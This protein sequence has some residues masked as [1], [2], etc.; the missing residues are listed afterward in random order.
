MR[1]FAWQLY[2]SVVRYPC[3]GLITGRQRIELVKT[4]E[5]IEPGWKIGI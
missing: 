5:Q 4:M 3:T 1:D 2:D